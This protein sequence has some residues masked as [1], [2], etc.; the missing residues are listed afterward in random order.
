MSDTELR[1]GD[2]VQ[3]K[4]GGPHMTVAPDYTPMI[5]YIKCVWFDDAK[6]C[7]DYFNPETLKRVILECVWFDNAKMD[8]NYFNPPVIE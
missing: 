5:E 4:S 7:C 1:P 3:L 2:I 8:Y 6:M